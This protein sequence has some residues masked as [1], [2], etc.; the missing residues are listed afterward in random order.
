MAKRGLAICLFAT[1]A[2]TYCP[3]QR[4]P[5]QEGG[6]RRIDVRITGS[7]TD[8]RELPIAGA[9]IGLAR[10]DAAVWQPLARTSATGAFEVSVALQVGDYKVI[11]AFGQF[12]IASGDVK[13][14]A[15]AGR[16]LKVYLRPSEREAQR[17]EAPSTTP[18]AGLLPAGSFAPPPPSPV[19]SQTAVAGYHD[20]AGTEPKPGNDEL[21][22]VF[23]VTNRAPT[24]GRPAY[25]SDRPFIQMKTSYGV[26]S[27]RMPPVHLPGRIERPSIWRLERVEDV[28][29]HIVIA[30]R[31]VIEGGSAFQ[32]RLHQALRES[33]AEALLFIHG[34][35]VDFD[36]AVR[37]TAQLFRDLKFDGVPILFSWPGQDA[38]W[39]YP[40]AEDVV[41]ASARQLAEFLT[42][43][44]AANQ[45]LTAVNIIAHSMGNRILMAALDRL[46]LQS[47]DLK[48]RNIVMA[49]PDINVADFAEVSGIFNR[50]AGRTTIYSSS[51]DVALLISKAFHSYPRVG[52]APPVSLAPGIDTVDASAIHQDVLGHS[53]FGDSTT[54]VRDMFLLIKQGLAPPARYLRPAL[55]QRM[56]YWVVPGE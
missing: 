30:K 47:A 36:D 9:T 34:Y 41:D 31:E 26:C 10:W 49:A 24:A 8:S 12:A 43:T 19:A 11:A 46:A 21:V 3:A 15:T 7:L 4:Q 37:R 45:R 54:V 5:I 52:E 28:G 16:T 33:G 40:A 14:R 56:Q 50:F 20:S 39:R 42:Q 13:V 32:G 2:A 17:D 6:G 22:N 23:Y 29:K 38:W 35:N 25:Y 48:F 55:L 44:M 53:Y 18:T 1:L 51:R 27:V